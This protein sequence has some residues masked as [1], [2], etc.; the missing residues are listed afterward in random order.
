MG[1]R[2]PI[3]PPWTVSLGEMV[4]VGASCRA[5]CTACDG[6]RDVDL[7]ALLQA[8]GPDACLWGKRVKCRFLLGC[9]G[10]NRF[11]YLQGGR[12]VGMWST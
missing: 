4:R 11:F 12:Y 1:K 5:M 2:E 9:A 6:W 7:Q 3:R 10:A 8:I